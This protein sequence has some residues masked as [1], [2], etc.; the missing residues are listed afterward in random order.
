[1][2]QLALLLQLPPPPVFM[3]PPRFRRRRGIVPQP[4]SCLRVTSLIAKQ[5]PRGPVF[6]IGVRFHFAPVFA[7]RKCSV[8]SRRCFGGGVQMR[9]RNQGHCFELALDALK[10]NIADGAYVRTSYPF[11]FS[12]M[13]YI[14]KNRPRTTSTSMRRRASV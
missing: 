1:M 7:R 8:T 6:G 11:T 9:F 5:P 2:V 14:F 13:L 12:P 3:Q 4:L 10:T